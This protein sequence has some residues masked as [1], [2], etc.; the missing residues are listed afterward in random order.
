MD[1]VTLKI[2]G[3]LSYQQPVS[4]DF[5]GFDLACITG[6]NGAGKS[7][8]L[9]A[10]TWALFGEARRA[11]DAVINSQSTAAEVS[12]DFRYEEHLYRVRRYKQSGKTTQLDFF[13]RA[14]DG[15]WKT[16]SERSLRETEERIRESLRL[17]YETFINA[18][19]FLQGKADQFTTQNA[20]A[21]KRI[22]ASILGLDI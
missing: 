17:E 2:S 10:I 6:A 5:D 20:A 21:R 18:S 7:T 14:E 13:V 4:L 11:D 8:L 19:F 3:F 1:P 16:L 12:F 22:L 9:D 15:S